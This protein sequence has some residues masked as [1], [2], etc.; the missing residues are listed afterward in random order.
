MVSEPLFFLCFTPVAQANPA[1]S[2]RH[3]K[4]KY[5]KGQQGQR[6]SQR[7]SCP[8]LSV[9]L[10]PSLRQKAVAIITVTSLHALKQL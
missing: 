2:T 6:A 8:C 10:P 1:A 5:L 7:L 3:R 4:G 9:S